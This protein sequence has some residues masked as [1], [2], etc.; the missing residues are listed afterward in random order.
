MTT[1]AEHLTMEA[2]DKRISSV[3]E[4]IAHTIQLEGS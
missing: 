4:W 3:D 2:Y 1:K